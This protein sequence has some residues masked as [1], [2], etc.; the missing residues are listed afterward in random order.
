MSK[1]EKDQPVLLVGQIGT[2]YATICPDGTMKTVVISNEKNHLAST[3][4]ERKGP[5]KRPGDLSDLHAFSTSDGWLKLREGYRSLWELQVDHELFS[6]HLMDVTGDGADDL[7][8]C[9]WDGM[10][11]IVDQ[12]QNMAKFR[13]EENVCAFFA[14]KNLWQSKLDQQISGNYSIE[15]NKQVPCFIFFQGNEVLD[16]ALH[17]IYQGLSLY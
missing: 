16:M 17:D 4:T 2:N 13:C 3:I 15:I 14:G 5:V 6:L 8:A 10:T 1:D 12:S 7:V 11:Y 9:A